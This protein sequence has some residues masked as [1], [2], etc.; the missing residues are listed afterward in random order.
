M[1]TLNALLLLQQLQQQLLLLPCPQVL[2]PH[3]CQAFDALQAQQ[4]L[5]VAAP[6]PAAAAATVGYQYCC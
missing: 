6:A 1:A 2:L 5:A 3:T 4:A